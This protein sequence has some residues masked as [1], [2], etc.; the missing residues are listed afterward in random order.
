MISVIY[1][2]KIKSLYF[3][4]SLQSTQP[5]T[6]PRRSALLYLSPTPS[7]DNP[8]HVPTAPPPPQR[9]FP[10]H[11][12]SP[13]SPYVGDLHLHLPLSSS[14][15]DLPLYPLYPLLFYSWSPSLPSPLLPTTA[16]VL[17]VDGDFKSSGRC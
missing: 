8:D 13:T 17:K 2:I 15:A 14:T 16:E 12:R 11:R 7:P 1:V 9:L 4:S 10:A 3:L 6:A 5:A